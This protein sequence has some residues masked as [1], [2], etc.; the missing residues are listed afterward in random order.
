MSNFVGYTGGQNKRNRWP[1]PTN[2]DFNNM[3]RNTV[4]IYGV[5]SRQEQDLLLQCKKYLI[6]RIQGLIDHKIRRDTEEYYRVMN[7]KIEHGLNKNDADRHNL[8]NKCS[9]VMCVGNWETDTNAV[10]QYRMAVALGKSVLEMRYE[11]NI[12]IKKVIR[13]LQPVRPIKDS[14]WDETKQDDVLIYE[15]S[16]GLLELMDGNHRHEF[17]NRVG[18]VTH[19]SGWIMKQI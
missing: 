2:E 19:L 14:S 12:P 9:Y 17:A 1:H 5:G 15:T 11:A 18:G 13:Y 6:S 4:N 3:I 8:I 16:E 10:E 7:L